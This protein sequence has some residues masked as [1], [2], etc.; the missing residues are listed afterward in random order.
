MAC[1]PPVWRIPLLGNRRRR[2]FR[3]RYVPAPAYAI[4][5]AAVNR[6]HIS[7]ENTLCAHRCGEQ[8]SEWSARLVIRLSNLPLCLL[9]FKAHTGSHAHR[10]HLISCLMVV[11]NRGFLS[12]SH[13]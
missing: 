11:T 8:T 4:Y 2:L 6:R 5:A 13:K 1:K 3:L 7:S 10:S 9:Q 12:E